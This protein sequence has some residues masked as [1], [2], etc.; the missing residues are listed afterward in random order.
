MVSK[1][2]WR[3]A[4]VVGIKSPPS[5]KA[6]RGIA[7][8]RAV[9]VDMTQKMT[10]GVDI[11]VADMLDAYSDSWEAETADGFSGDEAPGEIKD[12]GV[13]LLKLYHR[14]VAP[15]IQPVA[16]ELPLQFDISGQTYTGQIDLIEEV[17]ND[18]GPALVIRDTKTTGRRPSG[19]NY[20]LNMTGYALGMRQQTGMVE[21]DT[22]LDY[23]V[24]TNKPYYHEIRMGGPISDDDIRRFAGVVETVGTAINAGQFLPNGLVSGACSWCGYRDICPAYKEA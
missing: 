14:E 19:N 1:Y 21:A 13:K 24:A 5:L 17:V 18:E 20:L 12:G 10:S 3:F 9:E 23:L 16:V 11:P 15:T 2:Q 4:Y 22:V 8:H 7:V 6:V